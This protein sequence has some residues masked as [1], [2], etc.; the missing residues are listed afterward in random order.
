[1]KDPAPLTLK[2]LPKEPLVSV[3][4]ANYN[5]ADFVGKA[6]KSVLKQ[7]YQNFEIV[8]C[9][10]GS[11]DNSIDVL[12]DYANKEP[13][14]RIVQKANGGQASALN[15]AYSSSRGEIIA[16]LDADDEWYP[17]RLER[18]VRLF[19]K[20]SDV[21]LI[22]HPLLVVD[23]VGRVLK[24]RHPR[25][26][27]QGWLLPNIL[28]GP[29][30]YISPASGLSI[31][32]EVAEQIFPLPDNFRSL[33][34]WVVAE[35]AAIVT[36]V[37]SIDEVLGIYRQHQSNLT[38]YR[39][40]SSLD[41]VSKRIQKVKKALRD[42][43]SFIKL[44]H[45]SLQFSSSDWEFHNI[46]ALYCYETLLMGKRLAYKEIRRWCTK[47]QAILWTLLFQLPIPISR[48]LYQFW[49]TNPLIRRHISWLL[50]DSKW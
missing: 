22:S 19:E 33:A 42:R 10:D 7:S 3:L 47:K 11:T 31:R 2:P 37:A 35:R 27:D 15:S 45:P 21:G 41:E 29:H 36:L 50:S 44:K 48:A 13:R 26:L 8:V 20:L 24:P 34:D 5:H 46:G 25:Y 17:A 9:D 6:I 30:P 38:G 28:K 39:G 16:L 40:P 32:R 12:N 43:E 4:I 49:R 23:E 18:V 14:V 1:M